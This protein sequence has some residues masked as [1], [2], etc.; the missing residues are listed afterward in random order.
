VPRTITS[1]DVTASADVVE[2]LRRATEERKAAAAYEDELK[3]KLRAALDEPPDAVLAELAGADDEDTT[4]AC[5]GTIDGQLVVRA[6]Y[7]PPGRTLDQAALRRAIGAEV[8]D[9]YLT[10]PRRAYWKVSLP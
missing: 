9:Q 7:F 1:T 3:A 2:A 4:L 5:D 8:F 6:T 10:K